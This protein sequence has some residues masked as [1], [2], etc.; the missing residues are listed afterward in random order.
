MTIVEFVRI[1]TTAMKL[2]NSNYFIC[3]HSNSMTLKRL[4]IHSSHLF[5]I[6]DM[7]SKCNEKC[8]SWPWVVLLLHS[9]WVTMNTIIP[10]VNDPKENHQKSK[11]ISISADSFQWVSLRLTKK[12]AC[13]NISTL[14]HNSVCFSF[15]L[16]MHHTHTL[17]YF[18]P[19]NF[20]F[21]IGAILLTHH[22]CW[23][24]YLVKSKIHSSMRALVKKSGFRPQWNTKWTKYP[25]HLKVLF[26][27]IWPHSLP[28]EFKLQLIS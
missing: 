2:I 23:F 17:S 6:R 7:S 24:V 22:C 19:K 26:S 25:L 20:K 12:N 21:P 3:K 8:T 4:T 5:R 15:R 13:L 16:K 27:T 9:N 18:R 11:T 28:I 1:R 14:A 10:F